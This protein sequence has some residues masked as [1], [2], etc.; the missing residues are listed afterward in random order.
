MLLLL[1]LVLASLTHGSTTIT[2]ISEKE[3]QQNEESRRW[4]QAVDNILGNLVL[5]PLTAEFTPALLMK[6]TRESI[7]TNQR[8]SFRAYVARILMQ[9][10][11]PEGLI[12]IEPPSEYAGEVVEA[13][14][15]E[16][17][18]HSFSVRWVGGGV[19]QGFVVNVPKTPEK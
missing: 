13:Q 1:L 3:Q 8:N 14:V 18:Q 15:M 17:R 11:A 2:A 7:I 4:V 16:L 5:G 9:S 19:G 10:L 6:R 12:H